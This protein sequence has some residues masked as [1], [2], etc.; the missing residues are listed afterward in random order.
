MVVALGICVDSVADMVIFSHYRRGINIMSEKVET[1]YG[2][3]ILA[4]VKETKAD[5]K[6][7]KHWLYGKNGFEGDIPQ[8]KKQYE[9]LC[10][11]DKDQLKKI[12]RIELILAA[13]GIL[14]GGTLGIIKLLS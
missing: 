10:E 7:L 4:E 1:I 9:V 6:E 14:G 13:S 5:I 12:H 8:L 11:A 3:E 2:A